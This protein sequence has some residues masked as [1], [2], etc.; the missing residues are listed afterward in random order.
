MITVANA[1]CFIFKNK[2]VTLEKTQL[3]K[4]LKRVTFK[5]LDK[6]LLPQNRT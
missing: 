4:A 2:T 3:T 6:L 5:V 1:M